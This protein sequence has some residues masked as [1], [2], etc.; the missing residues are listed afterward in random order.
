MSF[1]SNHLLR[2]EDFANPAILKLRNKRAATLSLAHEL[3]LHRRVLRLDSNS[4]PLFDVYF[5]SL[6]IDDRPD[7]AKRLLE[8]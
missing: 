6:C 7:R 3:L 8:R 5:A 4:L 2:S 1:D